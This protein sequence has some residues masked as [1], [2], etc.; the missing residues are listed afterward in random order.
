MRLR[1]LLRM[2]LNHARVRMVH[3]RRP[4]RSIN[5]VSALYMR[6]GPEY[7]KEDWGHDHE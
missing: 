7:G 2:I 5:R 3:K 1:A 4:A 6:L